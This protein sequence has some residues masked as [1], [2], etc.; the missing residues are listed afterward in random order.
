MKD[1]EVC[2]EEL[3]KFLPYVDNWATC[4]Q[5]SPKIFKKNKEALLSH[6][7]E[8]IKSDKTYAKGVFSMCWQLIQDEVMESVICW[9]KVENSEEMMKMIRP[10]LWLLERYHQEYYLVFTNSPG[11][12]VYEDEYQVATLTDGEIKIADVQESWSPED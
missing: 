10:A 4:D 8:W 7:E 3:E 5:M 11:E 6:I 9:F 12:I 1:F 2:M